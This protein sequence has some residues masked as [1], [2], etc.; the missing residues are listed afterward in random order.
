MNKTAENVKF[1]KAF[2]AT[3]ISC[4]VFMLLY[5]IYGIIV[6]PNLGLFTENARVYDEDWIRE[7]ADGSKTAY[8]MPMSLPLT[9]DEVVFLHTMLPENVNDGMYLS[10]NTGKCFA[11]YIDGEEIYRFDNRIS[12]LP[13]NIT[14]T[15]IVPVPLKEDYAGKQLTME[16]TNG[17]YDRNTVNAAYIGT[18]MGILTELVKHYAIQ[19]MM[20][21]LL[22]LASLM[23]IGVFMYIEKR[24]GRKAPLI[25]LAEG[26][27]LICLWIICD[28]PLFQLVFGTY[29]FDGILGF[30]L[31]VTMAFPFLLY[32]DAI[33]EYRAHKF[34]WPCEV[35]IIV[36]FVV[37]TFLHLTGIL[38][39]DRSLLYV[40]GILLVYIL[41]IAVCTLKD[42]MSRKDKKHSNVMAGMVGLGVFGFFEIVET[43]VYSIA[44]FTIDI[45]G[46]FVLFGMIILLF[47]AILDQVKVFDILQSETRNAIAAT[48]AK[49]DFLASMSHEIR[50]PINAIMGM[51]EMI[52][53]E[54]EQENVREYAKDI[55]S[56]SENL[57]NIVNDILDFSKIE[58]GKL[59]L[60]CDNYDL[61]ELIYDV[62]NLVNMKAEDKG[63]K[64]NIAVDEKLPSILYGDDKRVREIITNILNNAVKYTEKGFVNFSVGGERVDGK[65][66][67]SVKVED[68]GQGIREED[69]LSIF[70]GFSQANVRKNR[71]IEGT[72]LG[73]AITKRLVELM[74]GSIS[75]DSTFGEGS[76]FTVT[77]PQQIVSDVKLGN[78]LEHRHASSREKGVK[79]QEIEIPNARI[80]VVDDTA[81]NLKVLS[82]I[83][84]KTKADVTCV[85]SGQEML[86]LIQSNCYDLIFLDH[87]MPNMDGIEALKLSKELENNKCMTTPVIALTANAILGAREMYLEAGFDDYLSKPVMIEDLCDILIK[88]IP[89]AIKAEA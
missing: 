50:T 60:I 14:K 17:I 44:P 9:D 47:F 59:E 78:Y 82:K 64:F 40:D 87:M 6:S 35:L 39:Y 80:M 89:D 28:S 34:F 56:A 26:I 23:T 33:T 30:M 2:K 75:V 4:F 7:N 11:M 25:Y 65:V 77:I 15:V 57:L 45:G 21:A 55:G 86:E 68:S 69:L 27:F 54:S 73:L 83:L 70:E 88:Y 3:V 12:R 85:S 53:R 38:S 79:L 8:K 32:F 58:S 13:G 74:E 51:N 37:L 31:V 29:F 43:I 20:A 61:G 63:L 67:L 24:D 49:S 46:L 66:L 72:G 48:K 10:I 76:I 41:I 84:G 42:Y 22:V 18:L 1:S 52:L 71:H 5:F 36:N 16:L 81:L 62:A 19:L